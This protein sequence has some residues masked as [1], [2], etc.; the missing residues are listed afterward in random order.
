MPTNP[1]NDNF[2]AQGAANIA[3]STPAP[4]QATG[5]ADRA[6]LTAANTRGSV[7]SYAPNGAAPYPGGSGWPRG[8]ADNGV[9]I[10]PGGYATLPNVSS[11]YNTVS[12]NGNGGNSSLINPR[13]QARIDAYNKQLDDLPQDG[14]LNNV[15][16]R[17]QLQKQIGH[18]IA[19]STATYGAGSQREI[20]DADAQRAGNELPIAQM[21]DRTARYGVDIGAETARERN[22]IEQRMVENDRIYH[23]G[24]LK[25]RTATGA[26]DVVRSAAKARAGQAGD[27]GTYRD[28]E[29]AGVPYSQVIPH[30]E[31]STISPG[32]G[33][34]TDTAGVHPYVTDKTGARR[35]TDS[36]PGV[37]STLGMPNPSQ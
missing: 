7:E 3:G 25:L 21:H 11:G 26:G 6:A 23:E 5:A 16:Q 33:S 37:R 28:I 13:D 8:G 36:P 19:N 15:W 30:D 32:S 20:A 17:S 22:D 14:S 34:V 4:V 12:L 35:Y 27:W 31:F 29:S 9:P 1:I 2:N 24:D 18:I 10:P